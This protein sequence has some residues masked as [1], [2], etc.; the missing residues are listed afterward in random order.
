MSLGI[1]GWRFLTTADP[2]D[3]LLLTALAQEIGE[4]KKR[5]REALAVAIANAVGRL[6]K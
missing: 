4:L 5:E 1:D 6:F 3:Q 2:V